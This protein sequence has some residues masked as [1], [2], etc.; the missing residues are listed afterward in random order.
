MQVAFDQNK[1][2]NYHLADVTLHNLIQIFQGVGQPGA[3]IFRAVLFSYG[4]FH[5]YG[6]LLYLTFQSILVT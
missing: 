3:S 4:L 2:E 1:T 5:F 6:P